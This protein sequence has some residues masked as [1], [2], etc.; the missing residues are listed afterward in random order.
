MLDKRCIYA[1]IWSDVCTNRGIGYASWEGRRFPEILAK[2]IGCL[3]EKGARTY[4][5]GTSRGR[6]GVALSRLTYYYASKEGLFT[7]V[8][9]KTA[10][11]YLAE[12][13]CRLRAMNGPEEKIAFL[14]VYFKE[15]TRNKPD[16]RRLF[17][18]FSAHALWNSAF[19]DQLE[20]LFESRAA[21]I[22][23]TIFT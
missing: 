9:N 8:I 5:C 6:R 17:V 3:A 23:K 20:R 22:E 19:A 14:P 18:D 16:N 21:L 10:R 11:L 12:I 1:T 2:A 15:L 4:S 13:D 7:E